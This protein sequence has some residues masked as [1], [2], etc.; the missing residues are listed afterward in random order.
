MDHHGALKALM[1]TMLHYLET[2]EFDHF[3]QLLRTDKSWND[4]KND[5]SFSEALEWIKT[6]NG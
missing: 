6:K 1:N 3:C 4:A 2:E 5:E